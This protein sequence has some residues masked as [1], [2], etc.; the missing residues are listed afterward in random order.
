MIKFA[1]TKFDAGE[2]VEWQQ[3]D[4]SDLPFPAGAFD[5]VICQFGLMFVPDKIQAMR[6]AKRVLKPAASF[7]FNV[8]AGLEHNDFARIAHETVGAFFKK[9]PPSFYEIPFGYHD[10]AA[11][12]SSLREAGFAEVRSAEV[13]HDSR[14]LSAA[15]AAIGLVDGTPIAQ[16]I[17]ERDRAVLPLVREAVADA[18]RQRFG[19]D[20]I[21]GN[22]RALVFQATTPNPGR[23]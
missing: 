22:L 20:P 5:A 6:E 13:S 10:R 3:A 21:R 1:Q 15:T 9:D 18:L 23:T 12:E 16:A 7:L 4:A 11:I 14:A 2:F 17:T 8:W 19:Q